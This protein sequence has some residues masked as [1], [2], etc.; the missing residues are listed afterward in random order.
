MQA[1]SFKC[2]STNDLYLKE[3]RASAGVLARGWGCYCWPAG[4]LCNPSGTSTLSHI[5]SLSWRLLLNVVL[6]LI[7]AADLCLARS[8]SI[9]TVMNWSLLRGTINMLVNDMERIDQT[10]SDRKSKKKNKNKN[11]CS[12]C[13]KVAVFTHFFVVVQKKIVLDFL[14]VSSLTSCIS[15]LM[16]VS[17]LF[18]ISSSPP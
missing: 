11:E 16:L 14:M 8:S 3:R 7:S 6:S 1:T 4:T 17:W 15:L 5:Y 2:V 13:W 18:F 10:L 9:K 12:A